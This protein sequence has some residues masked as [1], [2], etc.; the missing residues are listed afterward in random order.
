MFTR[1]LQ[2]KLVP[3]P[4]TAG[5]CTLHHGRT[6]HYSKG[7]STNDERMALILNFRPEKMVAFERERGHDH[8]LKVS[9]HTVSV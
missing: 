5:S 1:Y 3:V 6:V 7:N 9:Y 8:G 4:L 2:N